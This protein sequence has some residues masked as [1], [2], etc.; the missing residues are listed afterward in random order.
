[1]EARRAGAVSQPAK[2]LAAA[3]VRKGHAPQSLYQR[4]AHVTTDCIVTDHTGPKQAILDQVRTL[5]GNDAIQFDLEFPVDNVLDAYFLLCSIAMSCRDLAWAGLFLPNQGVDVR[6]TK[7]IA[8]E[9]K[10]LRITALMA[11][12]GLCD[13]VSCFAFHVGIPAKSG[14]GGRIIGVVPGEMTVVVWWPALDANGNSHAGVK[15]QEA[16]TYTIDRAIY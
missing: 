16:F 4:W 1:L 12:C 11:T 10:T 15:M 2:F 7:R 9:H 3:G 6:T 14:V 8:T 13:A 5:S